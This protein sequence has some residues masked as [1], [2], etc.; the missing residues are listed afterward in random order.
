MC[1]AHSPSF[2]GV[3][4]Y[5]PPLQST[6]TAHLCNLP[7][8]GPDTVGER[9]D[10]KALPAPYFPKSLGSSL[11]PGQDD[12]CQDFISGN[13]CAK[14]MECQPGKTGAVRQLCR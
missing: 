9:S 12:V 14:K 8:L 11:M 10:F 5:P 2:A 4:V 13:T 1:H 7:I 3:S 6:E